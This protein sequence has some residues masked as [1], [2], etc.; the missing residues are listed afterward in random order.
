MPNATYNQPTHN[1]FSVEAKK[2]DLDAG[3]LGKCFGS[4]ANAPSNI[5]GCL[6]VVLITSGVAVL[7]VTSNIPPSE[8]WKMITPLITMSL[9]YIFGKSSKDS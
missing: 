6:L 8:Y 2:L 3:L 9:G 1:K 7:F 4:K 5:A